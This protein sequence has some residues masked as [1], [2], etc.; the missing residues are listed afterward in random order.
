[1]ISWSKHTHAYFK[2]YPY[3]RI[4]TSY[5]LFP[6]KIYF[7]IHFF[8]QPHLWSGICRLG[9]EKVFVDELVS[10]SREMVLAY[11]ANVAPSALQRK[12]GSLLR[13][14]L[15]VIKADLSH[16]DVVFVKQ[17]L[18]TGVV[19]LT[20]KKSLGTLLNCALLFPTKEQLDVL[21]HSEFLNYVY[22]FQK[23]NQKIYLQNGQVLSEAWAYFALSPELFSKGKPLA[24]QA[25]RAKNRFFP[26]TS[27][28][29][30]L[31]RIF[32]ETGCDEIFVCNLI[33]EKRFLHS[34]AYDKIL[35]YLVNLRNW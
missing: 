15:P 11:G 29:K 21:H 13:E 7:Y 10:D 26:S 27:H 32:Q 6:E 4:Q 20:L 9:R 12:L 22:D 2:D 3:E 19:P 17:I 34:D 28:E 33:R 31:K 23:V 35:D 25:C 24:C 8:E 1:M 30:V 5:L 18:P 14:P 16:F